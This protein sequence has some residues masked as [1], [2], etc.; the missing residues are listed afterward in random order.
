[1]AR[2]KSFSLVLVAVLVLTVAF[3][4]ADVAQSSL[5]IRIDQE[6]IHFISVEAD[7]PAV[8]AELA[9]EGCSGGG[10]GPG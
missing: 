2:R 7:T 6:G 8:P 1:M 10:N 3:S 5:V 9:C 4:V